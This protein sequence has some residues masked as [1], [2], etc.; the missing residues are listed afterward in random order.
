MAVLKTIFSSRARSVLAVNF[1][2]IL[3]SSVHTKCFARNSRTERNRNQSAADAA[4]NNVT[5]NVDVTSAAV[6]EAERKHKMNQRISRRNAFIDRFFGCFS[7][8]KN[9]SI[10]TT[11]Y[12]GS[13]SI[14]VIHGMR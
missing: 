10:I 3:A 12:L 13:D 11:N 4:N 14:E 2:L 6:A 9:S 7:V 5:V 1:C 8:T